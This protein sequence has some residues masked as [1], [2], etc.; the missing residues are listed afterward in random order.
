MHWFKKILLHIKFIRQRPV[1]IKLDHKLIKKIRPKRIPSLAQIKYI[2]HF[3]SKTELIIIKV[4][5]AVVILSIAG[6]VITFIIK[7]KTVIP[8]DG[9]EY[10][11]AIIGQPKYINP[12]FSSVSQI[13]SDLTYLIY[14]GLFRFNKDQKLL[15]DLASKYEINDDKTVYTIDLRQDVKWSDGEPFNADDVV[16]TFE[17]IQN[18]LVNSPLL[19]DFQGVSATKESEYTIKFTLKEPFSPFLKSLTLG[20]LPKHIWQDIP[21]VQIKLARKNLEPIGTGAWQFEK[22]IKDGQGNIQ[23]YTLLRN[24]YYY[25]KNSY[26][27]NLSFKFY[28]DYNQAISALK[29]QDVMALSF[30]P[31]EYKDK[32]SDKNFQTYN[33]VLPQYTALFFNQANNTY[34]KNSD[35][36]TA[37]ASSIDRKKIAEQILGNDVKII[38]SPILRVYG[39]L[40]VSSSTM[41]TYSPTS[42]YAILDKNW[43]ALQPE[44]YYDIKLKELMKEKENEINAIKNDAS[45]TPENVSSTIQAIEKDIADSIRQSMDPTQSFYRQDKNSNILQVKITTTNG[46][47]YQSV[48]QEIAKM[49]QSVGIKTN[50]ELVNK[51]TIKDVLK[52]RD[53]EILLYGEIMGNDPDPFPFWHSSQT[54]YPGLN[55]PIFADKE[56]DKLLVKGRSGI[57]EQERARVYSEFEKIIIKELPAI[58]LYSPVY[59]IIINK[60]IKGFE[61]NRIFSPAQRYAGLDEWYTKTKKKIR[62][63]K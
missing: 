55:L 32:I 6:G 30:I 10:I 37:L 43:K 12:L 42:T 60:D 11:E 34:L 21:P 54:Q 18:P 22:L 50:I 24:K 13:D 20:I 7:N 53:Y 38:D 9:G 35:F 47:E 26:L 4:A 46:A 17:S 3:L 44:E 15:P 51:S 16:F 27:K 2:K 14:S 45:S 57:D 1:T 36:R 58:F 31:S 23:S 49:W 5:I 59:S 52:T 61:I 40:Y 56:A 28:P 19:A 25:K 62:F 8:A 33:F 29:S 48:A 39:D 41:P 63:F